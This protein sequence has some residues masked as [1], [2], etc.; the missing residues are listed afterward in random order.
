MLLE[1]AP[2]KLHVTMATQAWTS[3]TLPAF[4]SAVLSLLT[5]VLLLLLCLIKKKRRMEGTYR[6]SAEERKQ[7]RAAGPEKPRLPLPLPKEE[8]LI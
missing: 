7:T 4:A 6:P 1:F 5:L 3:P 2:L 8:R